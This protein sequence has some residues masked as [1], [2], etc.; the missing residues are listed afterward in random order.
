MVFSIHQCAANVPQDNQERGGI[1]HRS[2]DFSV[3]NR[4]CRWFN[5]ER[6]LITSRNADTIA[7][8]IRAL[9]DRHYLKQGKSAAFKPWL[10]LAQM[11]AP[12]RLQHLSFATSIRECL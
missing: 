2:A 7:I 1:T 6:L 11:P 3:S 10:A 5:T 12:S 9:V 4:Q 8:C